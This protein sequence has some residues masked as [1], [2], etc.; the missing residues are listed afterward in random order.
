M[1]DEPIHGSSAQYYE[2]ARRLADFHTA[3]DARNRAIQALTTA[4][5]ASDPRSLSAP[6]LVAWAERRVN[7]FHEMTHDGQ[8][9]LERAGRGVVAALWD[10]RG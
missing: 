5:F 2:L 1:T 4:A 10:T 9:E 7:R 8:A 6:S 3:D